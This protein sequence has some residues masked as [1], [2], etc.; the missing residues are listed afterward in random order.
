MGQHTIT[1]I[2][3]TVDW[4]EWEK[5]ERK[6]LGKKTDD[7]FLNLMRT[8]SPQIYKTQQIPSKT[9]TKTKHKKIHTNHI[10]ITC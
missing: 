5:R 4:E 9:P 7:K 2:H 1:N 8:V 10:T 3:V 6:N